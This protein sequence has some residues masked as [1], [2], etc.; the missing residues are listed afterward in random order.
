[1]RNGMEGHA[2]W[3]GK[4]TTP[5]E[6]VG[7]VSIVFDAGTIDDLAPSEVAELEAALAVGG[8]D[9]YPWP[10]QLAG[11]N[12]CVVR[13]VRVGDWADDVAIRYGVVG[14]GDLWHTDNGRAEAVCARLAVVRGVNLP[15]WVGERGVGL[16]GE[17]AAGVFAGD[18]AF[19][20][21]PAESSEVARIVSS[22]RRLTLGRPWYGDGPENVGFRVEPLRVPGGTAE[23]VWVLR[24]SFVSGTPGA[25]NR[26]FDSGEAFRCLY[27][28][29]SRRGHAKYMRSLGYPS[30]RLWGRV[31]DYGSRLLGR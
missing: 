29:G 19:E 14:L 23:R 26:Y 9:T 16:S 12:G 2:R 21:S 7:P 25:L 10:W 22:T 6:V 24:D 4:S 3:R 30:G 20:L 18:V 17:S 27:E 13:G 28:F 15:H 8:Q 1:M 5:V 11:Y 31:R